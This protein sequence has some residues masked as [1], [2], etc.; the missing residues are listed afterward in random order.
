[1]RLGGIV[2]DVVRRIETAG[3]TVGEALFE[4]VIRLGVTGLAGAGKTVF[5][6]A[7]VA[8]LLERGRM[9]QLR[10]A[11]TGAIRAAYLRPQ[12]DV[13]VPRFD[14]ETHFAALTASEPRWPLSTRAV[15]QLRLSLK[16]APE[17]LLSGLA[18]LRTVHLD[19]VDY[20]GEWLLDLGLLDLD[21]ATWSDRVLA[22]AGRGDHRVAAAEWWATVADAAPEAP[23]DE[24]VALRLARG[25]T[26]YLA[27]LAAT[28][29]APPGPG[30]FLLP[31][32][33]EGSPVLTFAPLP[34]PGR[35][36]RGM[37]WS[38]ME[39]RFDAYRREVVRPFFRDHFARIDRQVVLADVL[40]A[41]HA[42]PPALEDLRATLAATL[43]AFRPGRNTW[44]SG[45][46]GKRVEHILFAATRAD[47]LHHAQHARLA[48]I[49]TALLA[50]ARSRAD[51]AGART[52][53]MA[54]ASVRATVEAA[55]PHMGETLDGVRGRLGDGRTVALYPGELPEEPAALL[56][57]AREGAETWLGGDF[58]LMDFRPAPGSHRPG[59]GLPH[60]R[61][62]RA[63]EFLLG[64]RLR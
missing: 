2:E 47:H 42:G 53:A 49:T 61:L 16:V 12:P 51:F 63:A 21:F 31:G 57:T 45:L 9:A 1:M 58:G 25:W 35:A 59:E 56:A 38:E 17:G 36:R 55:V 28:G 15:S 52:Q 13:T 8:N 19:I 22:R 60:I 4:P 64:D 43:G 48:A 44:L 6:T 30:R 50:E 32:A 54:I 11:R 20:P 46:L 26:G 29:R 5:I 10:A 18:G 40:G 39:R 14:F 34:Q 37:L 24:A 33:I 7:L 27:C 41:I 62:D 23:H 3:A